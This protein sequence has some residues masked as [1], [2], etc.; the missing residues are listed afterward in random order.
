[1]TKIV[2]NIF[3][4]IPNGMTVKNEKTLGRLDWVGKEITSPQNRLIMG[5]TALATQPFIDLNNK[6]VDEKTRVMSCA[7]TLA[8]ILVGTT[9][10]VII[11]HSAIKLAKQGCKDPAKALGK[12]ASVFVPEGVD[13]KKEAD[14]IA[15][16]KNTIGTVIGTAAGIVTNFI[17]DMPLTKIMTNVFIKK[18]EGNPEKE[19]SEGGKV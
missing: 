13:F 7:K 1:M 19:K 15:Q 17:I 11:R 4:R 6:K 12:W 8:K 14:F 9:V 16:H 2:E 5:V 10:G 18:F 3:N